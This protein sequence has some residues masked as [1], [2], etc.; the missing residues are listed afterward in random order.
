MLSMSQI[1]WKLLICFS[2]SF[3][4]GLLNL[5]MS[6]IAPTNCTT[7]LVSKN[8]DYIAIIFA[9]FATLFTPHSFQPPLLCCPQILTLNQQFQHF[10][11][12]MMSSIHPRCRSIP[13]HLWTPLPISKELLAVLLYPIAICTTCPVS[14]N[15]D[16]ITIIFADFTYPSSIPITSVM[17]PS[18]PDMQPMIPAPPNFDDELHSPSLQVHP[19]TSVDTTPYIQ[20]T[21]G[22]VAFSH[23]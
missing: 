21:A 10:S 12:L 6:K 7:C 1:D 18:D 17:L 16:Y 23:R 11:T 4:L 20:G 3:N 15:K 5:S 22:G 19:S 8:K 9:D 14:K 13:Q 2:L